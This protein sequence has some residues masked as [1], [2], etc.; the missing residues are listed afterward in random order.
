M[1]T[2]S[3]CTVY[4]VRCPQS[5]GLSSLN[6]YTVIG[7]IVYPKGSVIPVQVASTF[8]S[9]NKSRTINSNARG[10]ACQKA[11][12][13]SHEHKYPE[14]VVSPRSLPNIV[15]IAVNMNTGS[16]HHPL[17]NVVNIFCIILRHL[18]PIESGTKPEMLKIS[19][20]SVQVFNARHVLMPG[21][22]IPNG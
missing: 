12:V 5:L 18:L 7:T 11:T 20:P 17:D 8:F 1:V 14:R 10:Q 19:S 13:R 2:L 3:N 4:I 6:V 15:F 21:R 16:I 22:A 9:S